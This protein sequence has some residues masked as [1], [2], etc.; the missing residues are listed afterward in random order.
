MLYHSEAVY[1]TSLLEIIKVP[2][3]EKEEAQGDLQLI[4]G[5]QGTERSLT[6]TRGK[7]ELSQKELVGFWTG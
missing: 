5:I 6:G 7:S 3:R 1:A 4:E 2:D